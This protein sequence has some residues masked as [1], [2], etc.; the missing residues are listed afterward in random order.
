MIEFLQHRASAQKLSGPGPSEAEVEAM[1]R[2]AVTAPD[3]GR[4]RPWRFIV[5]RGAGR[6][7]LGAL[8]ADAFRRANPGASDDE[9]AREAGKPLRAP[10][11]IALVAVPIVPHKI[12][13]IEQVLAAGAAGTQLM[14]AANALGYGAAWKTGSAAH[15]ADIRAGL[16]FG[17]GDTVIGYFYIGTDS[18]TVPP[19]PRAGIADVVTHWD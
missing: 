16:G 14:L 3:H 15:D 10:V 17:D 11:V 6:E 19:L 7:R 13:A 18:K 4:L 9:V 12:P 8:M 1:L 5:M 2:A